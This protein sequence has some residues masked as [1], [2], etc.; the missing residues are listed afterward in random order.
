M[1][2]LRSIMVLLAIQDVVGQEEY[3]WC[4]ECGTGV[5]GEPDCLVFSLASSWKLFWRKCPGDS[6]CVKTMNSWEIGNELSAVRGCTPKVSLSGAAH[7][8][9]CWTHGSTATV[10]CYCSSNLC[11]GA[12]LCR[13]PIFSYVLMVI[14]CLLLLAFYRS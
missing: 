10:T 7:Q 2:M 8:E 1:A 11:N 12:P 4:Y 3:L 5:Q 6:V 9:G 13:T 14:N